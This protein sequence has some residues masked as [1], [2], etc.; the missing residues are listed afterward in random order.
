MEGDGL[1]LRHTLAEAVAGT[2]HGP[3]RTVGAGRMAVAGRSRPAAVG[4][5][6]V[7]RSRPAAVARSPVGRSRPAAHSP[8]AHSRPVANGHAGGNPVAGSRPAAAGNLP[9]GRSPGCTGRM[10]RTL[11]LLLL[12]VGK[13]NDGEAGVIRWTGCVLSSVWMQW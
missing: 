8:V 13:E 9:A 12:V 5:N 11:L 4:R 3:G 6:P 2:G 1:L 7:A 10:G